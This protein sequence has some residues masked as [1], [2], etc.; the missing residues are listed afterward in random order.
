MCFLSVFYICFIKCFYICIYR[1]WPGVLSGPLFESLIASTGSYLAPSLTVAG[2]SLLGL[3]I[4]IWKVKI[5]AAQPE[6]D[7]E[8]SR[9]I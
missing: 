7:I 5:E 9:V 6:K 8:L 2:M 1:W 4:V 3:L